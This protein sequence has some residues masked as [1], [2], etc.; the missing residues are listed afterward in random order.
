MAVHLF[1]KPSLGM[2]VVGESGRFRRTRLRTQNLPESAGKTSDSRNA[3]CCEKT[4]PGTKLLCVRGSR[5]VAV[6]ILS[7]T[8]PKQSPADL[9]A[10]SAMSRWFSVPF[11][12]CFIACG[13]AL[14]GCAGATPQVDN[15][16]LGAAPPRRPEAVALAQSQSKKEK[17][18]ESGSEVVNVSFESDSSDE[19]NEIVG[20][21]DG[22]P[23]FAREVLE[24]DR[25][26]L[27]HMK[28]KAPAEIYASRRKQVLQARLIPHIEKQ[29]L[30]SAV[31]E[32]LNG[33]QMAAVDEQLD[34]LF[35]DQIE[36]LKKRAKVGTVA[37]LEEVLAKEG[38]TIA[39]IRKAFYDQQLSRQYLGLKLQGLEPP[40]REEVLAEYKRREDDYRQPAD[41][42]WQQLWISFEGNGGQAGAFEVL[43]KAVSELKSGIPF[44]V[45]V[46][47]YSDGPMKS[48]G[49]VWDYTTR[50]NLANKEVEDALFTMPIGEVSRPYKAGNAFQVVRVA[51]RREERF[52]PFSE[53]HDKLRQEIAQKR[54]GEAATKK[55]AELW[56]QAEIETRFDSDPEWQKMIT[57]RYLSADSAG[58]SANK[59]TSN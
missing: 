4:R 50:G 37:E 29:L 11:A 23:V 41:V 28:E 47:K 36:D 46:G 13:L 31:K 21:V 16:V 25:Q 3:P 20:R 32:E 1:G 10:V 42:K 8:T 52:T 14:Q 6:T 24:A 12:V 38:T 34:A 33:E 51:D 22:I 55:I 45:V 43:Q 53:M 19:W 49:G 17:A 40:S 58:A 5:K 15:P 2:P 44:D 59:P 56:A 57:E 30:L 54:Q 48:E 35:V 26:M 27:Q 18:A 7:T 9:V 39:Q